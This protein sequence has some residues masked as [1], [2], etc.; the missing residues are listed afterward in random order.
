VAGADDG[1]DIHAC[2]GPTSSNCAGG[3]APSSNPLNCIFYL[4]K[5]IIVMGLADVTRPVFTMTQQRRA[6][7]A[8]RYCGTTVVMG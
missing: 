4:K 7:P 3:G 6:K 8:C 5:T 2:V 1:G